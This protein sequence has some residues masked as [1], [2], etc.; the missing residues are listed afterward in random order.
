MKRKTPPLVGLAALLLANTTDAAVFAAEV[1]DYSPGAGATLTD[2]T[3]ALGMPYPIVGEGSGFDSPLTPFNPHYESDQLVQIGEGGHL[4]LRLSN[5]VEINSGIEQI[6]VFG[7]AGLI[8]TDF[9]NG[10][11]GN[12][13]GTFGVDPVTISFSL[14]GSAWFG[15]ENLLLEQPTAFYADPAET[16]PA[17]FGQNH[18]LS[19]ADYAGQDLAGILSALNGSAGGNWLSIGTAA[20]PRAAYVRLEVPDDGDANTTITAEIDAIA[21]DN[22]AVGAPIP[23]PSATLLIAFAS[24]VALRRRR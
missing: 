6:G 14:D 5:Y 4:V 12:P 24:A 13:V 16:S 8:D 3:A 21:I 10:I 18:A 23:E 1:I 2:P 17:D 11:A 7:N 9:P 22:R 15:A 19:L 20:I